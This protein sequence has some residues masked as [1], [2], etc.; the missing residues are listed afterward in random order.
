MTD[1]ADI[2]RGRVSYT[3]RAGWIDWG[4]A[5]G[6]G[7]TSLINMVAAGLHSPGVPA[8]LDVRLGGSPAAVINYKQTMGGTVPVVGVRVTLP[9]GPKYWIVR[10]N[11][12]RSTAVSVALGIFMAE[13]LRFESWQRFAW[14]MATDSGQSA[15]DLVSNLIGFYRAANGVDRQR[16]GRL[17]GEVSTAESQRIWREHLGDGGL[18]ALKNDRFQP[19]YFPS[20]ECGP[21]AGRL[22]RE[23]EQMRPSAEG[24]HWVR[25][26][27]QGGRFW[28]LPWRRN[29]TFHFSSNGSLRVE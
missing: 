10:K 11:L 1:Y 13:S 8:N 19:I 17:L 27:H 18:G 25:P 24:L 7:A 4:H 29:A 6:S 14:G 16:I 20:S 9:A 3:C 21:D 15:E 26:R 23:V 12:S 2:A 5:D 22:P 28:D